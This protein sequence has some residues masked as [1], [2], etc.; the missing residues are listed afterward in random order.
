M[1]RNGYR[2]GRRGGEG[3]L[4]PPFR[5][6]GFLLLRFP[7]SATLSLLSYSRFL[8][9][10]SRHLLLC[11]PS[12]NEGTGTRGVG[13]KIRVRRI[14][15]VQRGE[16]RRGRYKWYV[17]PRNAA[18]TRVSIYIYIYILYISTSRVRARVTLFQLPI[19]L[20]SSRIYSSCSLLS[21]RQGAFKFRRFFENFY[22]PLTCEEI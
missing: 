9:R 18:E 4:E 1:P 3:S 6:H 21:S 14:D 16:A 11:M 5:F 19:F 13:G 7:I 17:M 20:S 10:F 12:R 22:L 2:W 15:K 8:W